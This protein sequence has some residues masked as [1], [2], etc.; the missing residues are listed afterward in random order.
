MR[1]KALIFILLLMPCALFAQQD[2][3]VLIV[4]TMHS[5]PGIVKNSYRPLLKRALAYQ[6]QA[7]YVEYLMPDDYASWNQ[8]KDSGSKSSRE[9]Y[10][11][12]DS[13]RTTF[14]FEQPEFDRLVK[15]GIT[16]LSSS[17]LDRII[18]LFTYQRDYAN[19]SYY[20]YV[21]QYGVKGS[22]KSLG[23]ESPDLSFKLALQLG[24][25]KLYSIDDQQTTK[26][27]LQSWND[28]TKFGQSN[29]DT[30]ILKKLD[31]KDT[32]GNILPGLI[33]RLGIY[34]NTPKSLNRK[35]SINA[36]SYVVHKND[37]CDNCAE[38]WNERNSRI[39]KN[40][41]QQLNQS[42]YTKAVVIIG[43]GHVVGLKEEIKKQ[44]PNLRVRL[45]DEL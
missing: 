16:G 43:A 13:L 21:K 5:V 35:H 1:K 37:A 19:Y 12:S 20:T 25:N 31:K 38:Y 29:G 26:Q 40:L 22:K 32:R 36:T 6:P 7:I 33:G 23:N 34:T 8:I 30:D 4:G 11:L 45:L 3:E 18:T 42:S 10:K 24:I 9:F 17:E 15:K 41:I 39:A 28:C 14:F 27:Y 2:K 44:A